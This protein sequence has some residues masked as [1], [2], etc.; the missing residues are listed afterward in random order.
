MIVTRKVDI[1][2]ARI[3]GNREPNRTRNEGQEGREEEEPEKE[4]IIVGRGINSRALELH[5]GSSLAR[6]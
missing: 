3:N 5:S 4:E 6:N 1:K 2:D